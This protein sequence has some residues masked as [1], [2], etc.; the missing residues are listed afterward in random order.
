M[1]VTPAKAH[2]IISENGGFYLLGSFTEHFTRKY[3]SGWIWFDKEIYDV[4]VMTKA[5]VMKRVYI[6]EG[7]IGMR[8]CVPANLSIF[9]AQQKK[10]AQRLEFAQWG[11]A[12]LN[13]G[14]LPYY[15]LLDVYPDIRIWE[16]GIVQTIKPGDL[17]KG[18]KYEN[19]PC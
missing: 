1:T 12:E 17:K 13:G 10:T 15:M 7:N 9:E 4:P 14:Y 8:L 2:K 19:S 18:I 11:N 5:H 16:K 6:S 3:K